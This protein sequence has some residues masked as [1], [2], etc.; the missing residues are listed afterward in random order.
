MPTSRK[1][2]PKAAKQSIKSP[3]LSNPAATPKELRKW[4]FNNCRLLWSCDFLILKPKDVK[5]FKPIKANEWDNSAGRKWNSLVKKV[6]SFKI[7]YPIN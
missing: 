3:F 1:P 2:N 6:K 4:Q 5:S 7:L